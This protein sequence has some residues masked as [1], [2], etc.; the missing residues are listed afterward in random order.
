MSSPTRKQS[1]KIKTFITGLRQ[2]LGS[3]PTE[4]EKEEIQK[5]CIELIEFLNDLQQK[6]NSI[7]SAEKV[8]GV[9]QTVQRLEDLLM[10]AEANPILA[11]AFGLR[12]PVSARPKI[13]VISE[14][15]KARANTVLAELESLPID[16]IRHK[17]DN[18]TSYSVR[19]L[20]AIA[21]AIGIKSNK[22]LDRVGLVHLITTKIANYRG[23]QTLSGSTAQKDAG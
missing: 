5:S 14:E 2:T 15:E 4:S 3:L 23:Y 16:V 1:F 11:A 17:L 7:P 10:Q 21:S 22:N 19:N 8:D 9:R 13:A 20:R 18:E 12:R 6:L